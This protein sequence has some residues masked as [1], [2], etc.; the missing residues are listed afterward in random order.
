MTRKDELRVGY[1]PIKGEKNL[2]WN[3]EAKIPLLSKDNL[4]IFNI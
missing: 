1:M 2:I 4:N 3:L